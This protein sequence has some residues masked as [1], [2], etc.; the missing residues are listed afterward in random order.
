[1]LWSPSNTR[2]SRTQVGTVASVGRPVDHDQV[3]VGHVTDQDAD[4][5]EGK[6]K[7]GGELGDGQKVVAEHGDGPL[8]HGQLRRQIHAGGG[9]DQRLDRQGIVSGPGTPAGHGIGADSSPGGCWLV[10]GT[11]HGGPT[12]RPGYACASPAAVGF[13][14]VKD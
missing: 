9:G 6:V 7:L 11:G 1:M 8:L 13:L 3:L 14:P 4:D 12:W 10:V 2:S 5:A